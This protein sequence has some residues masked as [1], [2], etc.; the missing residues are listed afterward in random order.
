M[1]RDSARFAEEFVGLSE[2]EAAE[3]V[4]TS[5]G[6]RVVARDGECLGRNDDFRTDRVNVIVQDGIVVWAGR[7]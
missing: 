7:F 1:G 3:R 6:L 4:T 2:D 5:G